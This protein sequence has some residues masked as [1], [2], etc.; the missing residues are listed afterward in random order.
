[1]PAN[2][3]AVFSPPCCESSGY[4]GNNTQAPGM[5]PGT[6]STTNESRRE[7]ILGLPGQHRKIAFRVAN[8]CSRRAQE[9]A[10]LARDDEWSRSFVRAQLNESRGAGRRLL[11]AAHRVGNS[12]DF[13]QGANRKQTMSLDI[14]HEQAAHRFIA[15]VEGQPCVLEYRL[16]GSTMTITHTGVTASLGG[17]GIAAEL[18]RYA[19]D[20]ARA[21]GWKVIP[22]CSY[23]AAFID[24][25]AEYRDLLA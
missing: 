7:G 16:S 22:A 11:D 10:A 5:T 6:A 20:A 15:I 2:R 3:F 17:R 9:R 4:K 8:A 23:S 12:R 24:K 13:A 25:H 14:D 21:N 1:M 19:L 18:T